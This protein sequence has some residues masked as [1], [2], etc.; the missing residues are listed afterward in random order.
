MASGAASGTSPR[1]ARAQIQGIRRAGGEALRTLH[2]MTEAPFPSGKDVVLHSVT[3]DGEAASLLAD[4]SSAQEDIKFA[5]AAFLRL[6]ALPEAEQEGFDLVLERALWNSAHVA[7]AR[8]FT[9]GKGFLRPGSRAKF[10]D[11]RATL[12]SSHRAALAEALEVR[13]R[14]VAHSVSARES[15]LVHA[16]FWP[17]A[18]GGRLEGVGAIHVTNNSDRSRIVGLIGLCQALRDGLDAAEDHAFDALMA[19]VKAREPELRSAASP[20]SEVDVRQSRR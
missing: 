13:H 17:P 5:Q 10:D 12:S 3:V 8:P 19:D 7:L 6:Q 4:V 11:L 1:P 20:Q 14:H 15:V 9:T 18:F 16:D 2:V